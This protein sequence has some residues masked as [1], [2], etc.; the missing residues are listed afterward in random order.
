LEKSTSNK[1]RVAL[2][3]GSWSKKKVNYINQWL[4]PQI[5]HTLR[6]NN[7]YYQL[8]VLLAIYKKLINVEV[9]SVYSV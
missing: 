9:K 4:V 3:L 8:T 6:K 2:N 5:Y 1:V 7:T